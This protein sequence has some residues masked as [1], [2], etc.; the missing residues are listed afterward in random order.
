VELLG[1]Q[2][3][4]PLVGSVFHVSAGGASID[5]VLTKVTPLPPP[6]QID[7]ATGKAIPID[8]LPARLEPF[9]LLFQGPPDKLLPQA[10]HRLTPES[11]E[12]LE[13]FLVPIGRDE[14]ALTY[15]AV[16]G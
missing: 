15:E 6:R 3:F 16:F 9:S 7:R 14:K 13:I 10:I 12:S 2:F 1:L 11:G 4:A 8:R 5:L